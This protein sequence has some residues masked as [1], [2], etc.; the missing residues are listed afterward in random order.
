MIRCLKVLESWVPWKE[1]LRQNWVQA[2]CCRALLRQHQEGGR[3]P[4]C[5]RGRSWAVMKFQQQPQ[6]IP[7][8]AQEPRWPFQVTLNQGNELTSCTSRIEQ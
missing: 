3:E 8:S 4:G 6:P 7:Q 5:V 1:T 2:A